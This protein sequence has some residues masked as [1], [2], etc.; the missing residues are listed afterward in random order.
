MLFCSYEMTEWSEAI[1]TYLKLEQK[2]QN[3]PSIGVQPTNTMSMQGSPLLHH[4]APQQVPITTI[5]SV[6]YTNGL[7]QCCH[8]TL[9]LCLSEIKKC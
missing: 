4:T 7:V 8:T 9:T 6:S 3:Q 5:D 1:C 2:A